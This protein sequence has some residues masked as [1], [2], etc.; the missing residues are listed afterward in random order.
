MSE[1]GSALPRLLPFLPVEVLYA[2][3]AV[4]S[5]LTT[6]AGARA[7]AGCCGG[8]AAA[9]SCG[10]PAKLAAEDGGRVRRLWSVPALAAGDPDGLELAPEPEPAPDAFPCFWRSTASH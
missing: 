10:A 6:H 4:G 8:A 1:V 7:S 2:S 9:A 5:Y 3:F